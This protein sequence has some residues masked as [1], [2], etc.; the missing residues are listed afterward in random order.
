MRVSKPS[1]QGPARASADLAPEQLLAQPAWWR[2]LTMTGLI[3]VV[4]IPVVP[5]WMLLVGLGLYALI[6][7]AE[8]AIIQR[9]GYIGSDFAGL[10]A[11]FALSALHALAAAML[12]HFGDGGPRLFAVALIGFSA[13]NILLR[14]YSSPRMFLAALAPHAVVLCWVSWG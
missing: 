10:A 4:A 1:S 5:L 7:I 11:T 2:R 3:G 9:R 12:I 8:R 14:L 13:V 6:T